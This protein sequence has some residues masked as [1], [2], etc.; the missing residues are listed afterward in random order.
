MNWTDKDIKS[1]EALF[2]KLVGIQSDTGT[3]MVNR[4]SKEI[5]R[6]M[7]DWKYF[8]KNSHDIGLRAVPGDPYGRH[9]VW[10][11]IKGGPEMTVLLNHYDTAGIDCYGPL[12]PFALKP[13]ILKDELRARMPEGE[14]K[15]DLEGEKWIFGRGTCDMKA[16]TALQM[17]MVQKASE[18]ALAHPEQ[19]RGSL[20]FIS[21]C[22]GKSHLSGMREAVELIG[23]L[24]EVHGLRP[25][26]TIGSKPYI[27]TGVEGPVYYEGAA[28]RLRIVLLARGKQARY[29][30]V[31]GGLNAD[32][33]L[34]RIQMDIELNDKLTDEVGK[35][36]TPPPA[37][38]FSRSFNTACDDALPELSAAS[39]TLFSLR[40]S[41][42]E[43]LDAVRNI[44]LRA[45]EEAVKDV[46][47]SRDRWSVRTGFGLAEQRIK[48]RVMTYGELVDELKRRHGEG[49]LKELEEKTSDLKKMVVKGDETDLG[50]VI[51]AMKSALDMLDDDE[52][53][54]LI[55]FSGPFYPQITT[56]D[57][58]INIAGILESFAAEHGL[59]PYRALPYSMEN[60][61]FCFMGMQM[62]SEIETVRLN[63][64]GYGIFYRL[65]LE[66]MGTLKSQLL[67]IGPWG[68]D[69]NGVTERV[70]KSDLLFNTPNVMLQILKRTLWQ[71]TSFVDDKPEHQ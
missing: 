17:M 14:L 22:G 50:A 66:R 11:L 51:R 43:W 12:R 29:S 15:A 49:V 46:E 34:S 16:G 52:P 10:A 39:F 40:K 31:F 68:K 8:R 67:N 41:P 18:S 7:A 48:A 53:I 60:R 38:S 58:E 30:S 61:D 20:L 45:F 37:W 6:T 56:V 25:A 2:Y 13:G 1:L 70:N 69:M 4:I 26:L 42:K 59:E 65:P 71:E 47:K 27:K 44:S 64:P 55:G 19:L 9:I 35:V 23:E 24:G 62:E 5:Y 21:V 54:V 63:M 36:V 3:T 28:G 32:Y 33:L 57:R